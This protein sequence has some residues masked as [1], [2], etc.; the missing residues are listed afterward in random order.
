[1]FVADN[2]ERY[3]F[4]DVDTATMAKGTPAALASALLLKRSQKTDFQLDFSVTLRKHLGYNTRSIRGGK[5]VV[6]FG[7]KRTVWSKVIFE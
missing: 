7:N 5:N 1:M 2:T 4:H 3:M 6:L